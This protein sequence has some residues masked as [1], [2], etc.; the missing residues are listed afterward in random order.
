MNIFLQIRIRLN[1]KELLMKRKKIRAQGD[2][3]FEAPKGKVVQ[4]WSEE[5]WRR[6]GVNRK[7]RL[8]S[9]D[10]NR[11]VWETEIWGL[12]FKK[13]EFQ[14]Q[15]VGRVGGGDYLIA[16]L[17][18]FQNNILDCKII[19]IP[20]IKFQFTWEHGRGLESFVRKR[21]D[22]GFCNNEWAP[23]FPFHKLY[24]WK[25]ATCGIKLQER[26]KASR[27]Y[28]VEHSKEIKCQLE[29]RLRLEKPWSPSRA[30]LRAS[31]EGR[32]NRKVFG[33]FLATENGSPR[34]RLPAATTEGIGT[35]SFWPGS[36]NP[37]MA[38]FWAWSAN[39]IQ[40]P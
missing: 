38:S 17:G 12:M 29:N 30:L 15:D 9:N 11:E 34:R 1:I 20:V 18:G 3:F 6:L 37:K 5:I 27:V 33:D 19:K 28:F 40:P 32:S 16:W 25:V 26:H 23:L 21:L 2:I 7:P 39:P 4:G 8:H 13:L 36:I 22:R 10:V 31:S 14:M 24:N 35:A